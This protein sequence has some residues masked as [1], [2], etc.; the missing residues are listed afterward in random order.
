M[1]TA[2]VSMVSF[3]IGFMVGALFALRATLKALGHG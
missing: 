1:V 2:I 3:A